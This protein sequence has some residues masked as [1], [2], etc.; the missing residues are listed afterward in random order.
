LNYI[1]NYFGLLHVLLGR[2]GDVAL[3]PELV[4]NHFGEP[5]DWDPIQAWIPVDLDGQGMRFVEA[6]D[7]F[8]YISST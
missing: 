2:Q 4:W 5:D 8:P 1:H 7:L 6:K 3:D